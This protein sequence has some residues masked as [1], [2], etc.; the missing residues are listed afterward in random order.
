MSSVAITVD[1]IMRKVIGG[2]PISQGLKLYRGLATQFTVHLMTDERPDT[3]D[4]QHWLELQG[5]QEH[6]AIHW[7]DVVMDEM[8]VPNRRLHQ[9]TYSHRVSFIDLVVDP[10]PDTVSGLLQH[11]WNALLVSYAA[12][13][14][15]SWR[16]DYHAEVQPWN[17]M[18]AQIAEGARLRAMEKAENPQD[19]M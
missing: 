9:V 6:V 5:L 15:P 7:S 14:L 19:V 4:L 16:P 11:G 17:E 18:S 1:G 2:A 8:S 10:D 12:Y 13:S 3:G